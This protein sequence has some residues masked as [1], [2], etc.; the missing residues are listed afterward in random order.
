MLSDRRVFITV[1]V[2]VTWFCSLALG[3][4]IWLVI[5]GKGT[6]AVAAL[7]L[8]MLAAVWGK[9]RAQDVKIE[10]V[11]ESVRSAPGSADA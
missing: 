3:G 1:V 10:A 9:L 6:E 11:H 7:A 2:C 4:V 5:L 8:A